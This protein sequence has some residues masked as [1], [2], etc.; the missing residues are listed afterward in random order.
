[1]GV[2]VCPT[3]LH[4]RSAENA[5]SDAETLSHRDWISAWLVVERKLVPGTAP[6]TP[7]AMESHHEIFHVFLDCLFCGTHARSDEP[8][9]GSRPTIQLW[10]RGEGQEFDRQLQP[11]TNARDFRTQQVPCGQSPRD[12]ASGDPDPRSH[13]TASPPQPACG[14]RKPGSA[15]PT[16]RLPTHGRTPKFAS[17]FGAS[18]ATV[19][20][21]YAGSL[22]QQLTSAHA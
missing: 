20:G 7:N 16:T 2:P 19:P 4:L 21:R 8:S 14:R 5:D 13:V 11:T 22:S 17:P 18:H 9:F 10:K 3:R 6:N 1:M 15:P 12:F